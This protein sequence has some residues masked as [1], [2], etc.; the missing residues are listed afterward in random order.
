[1]ATDSLT[2]TENISTNFLPLPRELRDKIYELCLT[3][4]KQLASRLLGVNRSVNHEASLVLY[5]NHFNFTT[6]SNNHVTPFLET[7]GTNNAGNIQHIK[8]NFPNFRNL[9]LGNVTIDE[10]DTR[11]LESIQRRCTSLKSL[12]SFRCSTYDMEYKLR[13][14]HNP[15]IVIEALGLVNSRLRAMPS[16]QDIIVEVFED[17]P[18]DEIWEIMWNQ[19]WTIVEMEYEEDWGDSDDSWLGGIDDLSIALAGQTAVIDYLN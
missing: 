5:S 13:A 19:G 11:V 9:E 8:I 17:P 14:L 18:S 3:H 6:T 10:D 16:L 12:T 4:K 7:I 1:M 15:N 2:T